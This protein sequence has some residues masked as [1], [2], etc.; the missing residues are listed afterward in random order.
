MSRFVR[1]IAGFIFGLAILGL[2]ACRKASTQIASQDDSPHMRAEA[3]DKQTEDTRKRRSEANLRQITLALSDYALERRHLLPAA[4]CDRKSG[5]PLLSWRV[6][7]LPRIGQEDLYKQFKLDESWDGPNNKKLLEKM[8]NVYAPPG[9]ESR[10]VLTCYRG[11]TAAEGSP[12]RTAWETLV[13]KEAPL[14]F[15]GG[16]FPPGERFD[17]TSNTIFVV[18]TSEMVEWTKPGELDYDAKK[19]LPKLGGVF[20]DGFHVGLMDGAVLFF[21]SRMD[22]A[23]LRGFITTNGREPGDITKLHHEGLI[24]FPLPWKGEP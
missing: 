8:P 21:S 3:E 6:A 5:R 2:P 9:A 24:Q 19:P 11:L 12:H 14:G 7:L 10:G 1:P 22:D 18:E 20:K 13:D 4:I 23:T 16:R 15:W 17:G